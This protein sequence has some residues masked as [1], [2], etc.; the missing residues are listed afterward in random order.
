VN[1]TNEFVE[2]ENFDPYD[3]NDMPIDDGSKASSLPVSNQKN[4]IQ[5]SA[6]GGTNSQQL[7]VQNGCSENINN[8]L[9]KSIFFSRLK[10]QAEEATTTF[11]KENV[12]VPIKT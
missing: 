12:L 3:T 6:Q 9:K 7:N 10:K 1:K 4:F 8:S 11:Q 2:K 5:K